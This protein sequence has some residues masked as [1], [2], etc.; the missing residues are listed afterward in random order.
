[1]RKPKLNE[2]PRGKTAEYSVG[3]IT[4]KISQKNNQT[5]MTPKILFIEDEAV[6][7]KAVSEFLGVKGYKI[8][9]AMDGESGANIARMEKPDLILLDLILPKKN[10]FEV[11]KELKND[12]STKQIP[13]IV[14]TNLSEM[15]DIGKVLE[16]GV[17]TYMV[18]SDQTL[19]D[20][21]A[22]VEKT[23]GGTPS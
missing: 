11:L 21:F 2:L 18:K 14:L 23:L 6:M 20:I 10:G 12:E 15:G 4:Q 17:T 19:Q 7:Q 5:N 22:V 3:S 8:I 1:V 16:L 9:S 13:V